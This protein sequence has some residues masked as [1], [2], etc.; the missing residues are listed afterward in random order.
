[1]TGATSNPTI[2]GT[3][4]AHSD[5]YDAHLRQPAA[6]GPHDPQ[7]LFFALALDDV[8]ATTACTARLQP[9]AASG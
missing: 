4:I 9:I 3:A 5:R 7:E 1:V 8:R 6:G 2:F